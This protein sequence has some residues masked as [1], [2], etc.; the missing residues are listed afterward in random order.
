V[1]AESVVAKG[2]L[3]GVYVV[4]NNRV[5]TYRLVRLGKKYGGSVEILAGLNPGDTIIAADVARVVDGAILQ[6]ER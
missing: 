4:D 3:K 5:I 1:P 6:M 2:Q